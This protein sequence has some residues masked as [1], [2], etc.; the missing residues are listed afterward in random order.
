[1]V[2]LLS[3]SGATVMTWSTALV[4]ATEGWVVWTCAAMTQLL[5]GAE[6]LTLPGYARARSLRPVRHLLWCGGAFLVLGASTEWFTADQFRAAMFIFAAG[7]LLAL[8]L[9]VAGAF[10][11]TATR[12]LLVGDL[13]G[14]RHL[15]RQWQHSKE[16]E[17]AGICLVEGAPGEVDE[18][19]GFP[20]VGGRD[21]VLRLARELNVDDVVAAPGPELSAYDVRRLG[22]A[23]EK[24]D[25]ELVVATE[26]HG[27]VPHRVEPRLLG[28][29]LLLSVQSGRV[30]PVVQFLKGTIDRIGALLLLLVFLVPMLLLA[31]LIRLD[32]PGPA[33][34]RQVRVGREGRLFTMYKFRTMVVDA[35]SLLAELL[36]KNEAEGPLF[37]IEDDPRITRLGGFLRRTS[38][39][40]L[41]QLINVL[42]G[43]M[44]LIGPRPCLP[45]EAGTYDAWVRHRLAL[46]PGMTGAWQVG[47]RSTLGWDDSVRLDLDYVDNV[48]LGSDLKIAAQTV[49]AVFKLDGM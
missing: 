24:T 14:V 18:V 44:S 7:A 12:T 40:E 28:R 3:Y 29:R 20:V 2:A 21:D 9:R 6:F 19:L 36:E 27:A 11:S 5:L 30:S 10:G 15:A 48:S 17:I 23:L 47:G 16:V 41:P 42:K 32:R 45:V 49:K 1:L 34:F 13:V 31:L 8:F 26:V 46:K 22:W 33:L 43:D 4:F 25:F 37:K 35:E 39:D 38:L